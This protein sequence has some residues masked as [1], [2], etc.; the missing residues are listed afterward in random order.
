[1]LCSTASV[2]HPAKT[3]GKKFTDIIDTMVIQPVNHAL[4]DGAGF[5]SLC[6]VRIAAENR[7]FGS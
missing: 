6:H 2:A 5:I 3:L 4:D 1:M 7:L